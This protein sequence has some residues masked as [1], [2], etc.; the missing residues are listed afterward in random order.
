MTL[1]AVSWLPL[2]CGAF[3][4]LYGSSFFLSF[5]FHFL[6]LLASSFSLTKIKSLGPSLSLAR[7]LW[8]LGSGTVKALCLPSPCLSGWIEPPEGRAALYLHRLNW[9]GRWWRIC[10]IWP[11][12]EHSHSHLHMDRPCLL[13]VA[14]AM[15]VVEYLWQ[16][17]HGL[18][19]LRYYCLALYKKSLLT[20]APHRSRYS[21]NVE[22]INIVRVSHPGFT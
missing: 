17:L 8:M 4:F 3:F 14:S 6:F 18:K 22:W 7:C 12:L 1:N 19:S 15:G 13:L 10:Q 16:R 5:L 9:L 2:I 20:P 21:I 11:L